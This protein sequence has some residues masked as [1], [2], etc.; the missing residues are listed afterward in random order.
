MK[1]QITRQP[2]LA[3]DDAPQLSRKQMLAAELFGYSYAHYAD[4]LGIGNMRFE[5]LMPKD[6]DVLERAEREGWAVSRIAQALEIPEEKAAFWQRIFREGK[7]MV[8]APTLAQSFRRG[9]CYSIQAAVEEGL[10]DQAA[11]ERLVIQICYRAADLGFRLDMAR[12]RLSDYSEEL[13][14]EREADN[15]SER[16]ASVARGM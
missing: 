15:I 9:V 1:H 2:A 11:I 10:T 3:V 14:D 12:Q 8:D 13:R 4:H 5:K 6:I 16:V 7:E